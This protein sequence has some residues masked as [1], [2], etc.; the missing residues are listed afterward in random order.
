MT[1]PLVILGGG[2]SGL[3]AAI[4]YARFGLPA[5]ILEQHDKPGGLNSYYRRQGYLLE[6]GLHAMTN[7]APAGDKRAPLNRLF[8]QL[9]LSR[10]RFATHE[11]IC[12]EILFAGC[13]LRF[14]NDIEMLSEEIAASFP[15]QADGFRALVAHVK[16]YD[17]FTP[18]PW[19]SARE[20][21]AGFL[22]DPLLVDMVLCPLMIYGN[23]NEHDMDFAQFVIM[24]NA[25][26]LEGFFRPEGTIKDL[27]D[28][29]TGHYLALGGEIRYRAKVTGVRADG[30]RVR[31]VTLDS[32]EEIACSSVLST[33]GAPN[34][35]ALL[36]GCLPLE[37]KEYE[38][39]MSFMESIFMVP[40]ERC[41]LPDDRTCIFFSFDE[42][43]QY[44]RPDTLINP[45]AGVVN[46]PDSFHGLERK[47]SVQVRVTNPANYDLWAALERR[48]GR[49][50]RYREAKEKAVRD[51]LAVA[52]KI[53]GNFGQNIVY[54]DSFTPVTIER[55][56]SKAQGAVYGSPV[57]IKDGRTRYENLF[58][59]G[60]D[61]GYLGIV[62]AMLSGVTIVNQHLL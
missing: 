38:G 2:L 56:T 47:D 8:R 50:S 14:S 44:R 26:F 40:R 55:Y 23:A 15:A 51:S 41:G 9:K 53:V 59:A 27:L 25:V 46:F 28:L 33:I 22:S 30:G 43:Y 31:A 36:P 52:C 34:T 32:G 37:K 10:K 54:Q 17:P 29:L 1:T 20:V 19:K 18:A 13:S 24:F 3:A 57:K 39:R 35:L 49:E 16:E 58:V 7:F 61:Q 42:S 12:S 21:L 60:T 6:T 11:Q 48:P 62:G 45:R 4:R 5:L